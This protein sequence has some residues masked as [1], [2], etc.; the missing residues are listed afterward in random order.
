VCRRAGQREANLG[1]VLLEYGTHDPRWGRSRS[2]LNALSCR[3]RP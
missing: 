1:H 2:R 3:P